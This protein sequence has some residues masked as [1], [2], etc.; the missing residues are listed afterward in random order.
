MEK[1]VLSPN[2]TLILENIFQLKKE[3]NIKSLKFIS[4]VPFFHNHQDLSGLFLKPFLHPEAF[5]IP[6]NL[7]LVL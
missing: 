6:P 7:L 1:Q 3:R 2:A 4:K 5:D